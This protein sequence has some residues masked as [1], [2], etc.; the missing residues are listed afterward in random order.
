MLTGRRQRP[1]RGPRPR[2]GAGRRRAGQGARGPRHGHGLQV[3]A[4]VAA[5]HG[6]DATPARPGARRRDAGGDLAAGR[7]GSHSAHEP[8]R[9][10]DGLRGPR[11]RLRRSPRPSVASAYRD[12]VDEQLGETRPVLMLTRP[13][14][15]GVRA[16]GPDPRSARSPRGA[17]AFPAARRH[18]RSGRGLRPPPCRH[19]PG[20]LL[21][22]RL[23]AAEPGRPAGSRA[24]ARKP[25]SIPSR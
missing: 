8:S 10:G 9:A 19:R 3:V 18:R 17:G 4:D 14:A 20:R 2:S 21:P 25:T 23:A 12:R 1:L 24:A 13:L 5:T 16:P 7:R 11:G 6:G 15:A 22:A